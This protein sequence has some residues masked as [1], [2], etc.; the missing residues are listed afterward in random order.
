MKKVMMYRC[1]C[2]NVNA[3]KNVI[4]PCKQCGSEIC[5]ACSTIE[6]DRCL[7]HESE[8]FDKTLKDVVENL[9]W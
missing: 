4:K 2:G 6:G 3:K 8:D 9:K 1:K 7:I 5:P